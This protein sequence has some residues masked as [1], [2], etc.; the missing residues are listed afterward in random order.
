MHKGLHLSTL[1]WINDST[2]PAFV[3]RPLV[4][5][6]PPKYFTHTKSRAPHAFKGEG[7]VQDARKMDGGG[8]S[9][10]ASAGPVLSHSLTGPGVPENQSQRVEI[11]GR[12]AAGVAHE[13]NNLLTIALGSLEQLRR[14]SLD[15]RG[16]MQL[17]RAEWSVR[18]AGR[19]A[20]Q[21][22]S[23]VRREAG[24]PKHVDLNV[25][26]GEFDKIMSHA[27]GDRTRLVL[28]LYQEPLPVRLDPNQLEL[29]LLNLV[30]NATDAMSGSGAVTIRTVA[31]RSNGS[32]GQQTVGVSV[33]D[34]GSG[35]PPEIVE[36]ATTS[37]FTTKP[38]G[39]SDCGW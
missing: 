14:Q 4:S 21:V 34:T 5:A 15:E 35:M 2:F 39:K 12:M 13:F 16:H 29:A 36:R 22:L 6:Q 26:V 28:E 32:E 10:S 27:A 24:E 25:V 30:R 8:S 38:R 19:L 17:E 9:Q 33:S 1:S 11:L 3:S 7:V 37:F 20:Q 31:H 18:Q 23:F